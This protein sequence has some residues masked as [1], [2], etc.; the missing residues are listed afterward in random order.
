M[1]SQP[2]HPGFGPSIGAAQIVRRTKKREA[3]LPPNK[4]SAKY[5]EILRFAQEAQPKDL[6]A[7]LHA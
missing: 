1:Q 7:E 6:D 5:D 3:V 2:P 4:V